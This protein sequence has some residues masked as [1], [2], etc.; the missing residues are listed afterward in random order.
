MREE[1]KGRPKINLIFILMILSGIAHK[2]TT[3][4]EIVKVFGESKDSY[5]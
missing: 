5:R 2:T 4:N 1:E 3:P